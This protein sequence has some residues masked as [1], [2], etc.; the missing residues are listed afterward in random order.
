[1]GYAC[2]R[3]RRDA[4]AVDDGRYWSND[5]LVFLLSSPTCVLFTVRTTAFPHVTY[6]VPSAVAFCL[7]RLA[8]SREDQ[9]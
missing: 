8:V 1:M 3:G 2:D 7:Q 9:I 6:I 4:E 5:K